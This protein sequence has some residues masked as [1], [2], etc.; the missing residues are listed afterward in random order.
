M[1]RKQLLL[2]LVA[3]LGLG[4][5]GAW[6]L[7]GSAAVAQSAS[8][9][10]SRPK[11]PPLEPSLG[12]INT[13]RPL[14]L[15]DLRGKVVLLDFWTYGCINC[16]HMIPVL[17]ELE[18][19][20]MDEPFAVVGVHSAKFETEGDV[21]SIRRIVQR[22][23]IEH[24]VVVDD[25]YGIWKKYGVRAWPT[26][27]LIDPE[28]YVIGRAEGEGVGDALDR[29]IAQ[30]LKTFREK[31][32]LGG[33]P[34]PLALETK[35]ETTALAFPGKV[36]AAGDRLFIA[37]TN[38]HRIVMADT[39]RNVQTVIGSGSAGDTDGPFASATFRQPQGMAVDGDTLYVAD[40]GNHRIR[41][42]D[43]KGRTVRTV[44]S[45]G[46]LRSPWDLAVDLERLYIANAGTHQIFAM[47]RASGTVEVLVGSGREALLDGAGKFSALNQPSGLALDGKTLYFADAEA[48]AVRKVDLSANPPAVRTIVGKGLF[49]FGDVDGPREKA[50]LQHPLGV[51]V[52][53]GQLYI[54]DT[55][56]HRIKRIDP[57]TG[58][59]QSVL[60]DG[61]PGASLTELAEPGGITAAGRFLYIADTNNHRIVRFDPA[62]K[63]AKAVML[64]GLAPP[65]S[66]GG[67]EWGDEPRIVRVDPIRPGRT[68]NVTVHF[69]VEKPL[70]VNPDAPRS[71]EI[72]GES[73]R[74]PPGPAPAEVKVRP[75]RGDDEIE[76]LAEYYV[77][78][79]RPDALCLRRQTRFIIPV[80]AEGAAVQR[81]TLRTP[82]L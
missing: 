34:L 21:E 32:S 55:Y 3:A 52:L 69:D 65:T 62:K 53:G 70:K 19:K 79:D 56:N 8:D 82:T 67:K 22:Y 16:I 40:T 43:L 42:V 35:R 46:D 30:T 29:S 18:E 23:G 7:R 9:S 75:Q 38:H 54:A 12:W 17:K 13:S 66:A 44:A 4:L 64:L 45:G 68:V 1:H 33:A 49:E 2:L 73:R 39:E 24:P 60:G 36:L 78:E 51:T 41:Q 28:G 14:T 59:V 61:E 11:A 74:L 77:C 72:E 5:G 76:I 31:G 80:A 37:D 71:L 25:D 27:V 57:E 81:L 26:F 47:D 48:S 10:A 58:R 63:E 50:L 6:L 20:Y 15:A